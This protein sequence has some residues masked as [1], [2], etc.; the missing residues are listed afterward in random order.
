MISTDSIHF[1]VTRIKGHTL[2]IRSARM[3][4]FLD[5]TVAQYLAGKTDEIK[6]YVIGVEVFD[7]PVTHDPRIDPIVRVEARRLRE[8]LRAFYESEG[9]GDELL[10]EYPTGSYVPRISL[11]IRAVA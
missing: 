11:R 4:R 7:R 10:I 6:E 3:Q 8:K 1:Q 9:V 5:F 2:F